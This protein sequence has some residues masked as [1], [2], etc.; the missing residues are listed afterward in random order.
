MNT[1]TIGVDLAKSVFQLSMA[2]QANKIVDR[3][4]LTRS[5]F[6][7]FLM[8][9]PGCEIVM[10]A[11]ATSN[12]WAQ[13]AK[14]HGHQPKQLHALYVRPY[15]RRNKTDSA[16]A[17]ALVRAS[18]DPQLYPIPIK[19]HEQQALQALHRIRQQFIQTRTQRIN[20]GRAIQAEFGLVL[21]RGSAGIANKLLAQLSE[22]PASL[23]PQFD[24]IVDDIIEIKKKINSL[25]KQLEAIAKEDPIAPL[26]LSIPGNGVI[27]AT[28]LVAS[29][30]DIN[31]FKKG[32]QFS[33]FLG[34]TPR[35]HSSGNTQRLGRISKQ[36]NEYLRTMLIHG[37]RSVMVQAK[38]QSNRSETLTDLHRWVL[39][40]ETRRP[41]NVVTVALA[42]KLARIVWAVWTTR[43]PYSP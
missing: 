43:E 13:F 10:E 15:V 24:L 1:T 37:A 5:Q 35:E 7:K 2:N 38:R 34:I 42:N 36:G 8:L 6:Q 39:L 12:Y 32:R 3:K 40:M 30:V 21:P 23:H 31:V 22:I 4:R 19:S 28:V 41:R 18:C 17:D 25:D 29:V 27:T 14:D 11:C 9:Q 26:L 20:I 33:A 16:D